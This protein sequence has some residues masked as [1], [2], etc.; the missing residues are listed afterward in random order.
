MARRRKPEPTQP[1]NPRQLTIGQHVHS[2]WCISKFADEEGRVAVLRRG[3]STPFA[4]KPE[5]PIFCA[6]R[7]WDEKLEHGLFGKVERAFHEVV[8][9]TLAGAPVTDHEHV[10]AY[11]VIWQVR[12]NLAQ[13]PPED[14]NLVG[15]DSSALRKDEEE[16]LEQKGYMFARGNTVP[17]RFGAFVSTM[18]A[19]H[20]AMQELAG[21]RWGVLRASD[22]LAFICPDRPSNELYIPISRNTAL[23]AGYG[24]LSVRQ[25]TVRDL[26][27]TSARQAEKYVF[28]HPDDMAAFLADNWPGWPL[29]PAASHSG[30]PR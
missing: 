12:S 1:G 21:T 20:S 6:Q 17:G 15:V 7:A 8:N 30:G 10:T 9:S 28:G 2:R 3:Q 23:V 14:I 13:R 11:V 5:N 18:R 25:E 4:P 26:N 22:G 16:I 27:R 19:Y 29:K 24:D